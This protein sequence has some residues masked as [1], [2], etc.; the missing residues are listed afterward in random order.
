MIFMIHMPLFFVVSGYLFNTQKTFNDI[1]RSNI[2]GLFIPYILY[3]LL[4]V[5]YWV[6]LGFF[7]VVMGQEYSWG[8]CLF[9]PGWHFALGI[10]SGNY[11][12]PTWF[13]LAL[14][15]CK[16]F[17]YLI[18]RGTLTLKV[19]AV[20]AWVILLYVRIETGVYYIYALDCAC[21]GIIWFEVGQLL[22]IYKDKIHVSYFAYY[23]AIPIGFA[24]CY[25]VML[26]NGTCN[27][28]LANVNGLCGVAG[29]VCG[30]I[31]FFSLCKLLERYNNPLIELVSKATIVIMCL[32]MMINNPLNNLLHYWNHS[33]YT[34]SIDCVMVLALSAIYPFIQKFA[35]ALI[36]GKK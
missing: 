10:A 23:V 19:L 22:G 18:H 29:T 17:T 31:A 27:Y 1:T 2:K 21:A 14:I 34:F 4:F 35:P 12:G 24:L 16:Y 30:L 36:G 28:I 5:V 8:D 15:W 13:L 20:A 6:A 26:N 32:H 11:D 9:T 3:N 7:K 25:Y 33:F